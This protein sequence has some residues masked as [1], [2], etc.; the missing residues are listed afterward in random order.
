MSKVQMV[1]SQGAT[2]RSKGDRIAIAAIVL[3]MT[4]LAW[5]DLA[6]AGTQGNAK[7][8]FLTSLGA[9]RIV[10]STVP[11]N[12]DVNP[13]GIAV[14]PS[15]VGLLKQGDTLISNF[16]D[17]ANV[18]GT[19]TTIVE[20]SPSGKLTTF[21]TIKSLPTTTPCPGG[22]GLTTALSILPGDW[23]VV[24]SL[25]SGAGGALPLVNPAGCLIVLSPQGAVVETW[26]NA[27]I[28]GP[29]DMAEVTTK[30]GVDLFVANVLSRPKGTSVTP[31]SGDAST[32]VRMNISLSAGAAPRMISSTVIGSGFLSKPNK[33]ALV[34]GATGVA[35]GHNGT[36]YVAETVQNRIAEISNALTRTTAEPDGSKTLTSGGWLN[37]PLGL[38][39]A[40][41]GDV[42]AMNG[43]NGNAVEISPSGH[44]LAKVALVPNGSGDLF[45]VTIASGGHGLLFVNDGTNALDLSQHR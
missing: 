4:V 18:Q 38:T 27:N 29:W 32:I 2:R 45:G 12:G 36:L 14:V 5:S 34:Q 41:N 13:Y 25:P 24:G 35:L 17:K 15:T 28:N 33:A 31:P 39:L 10:G 44:Q 20:V 6:I 30:S 9:P 7:N 40:P 8:A 43:S 11:A 19:G 42:I 26:T 21:A 1:M 16:N 37:G 23:V 3:G 22:V